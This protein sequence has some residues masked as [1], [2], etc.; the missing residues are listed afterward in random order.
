MV[1]TD[2]LCVGERG[3]VKENPYCGTLCVGSRSTLVWLVMA[4]GLLGPLVHRGRGDDRKDDLC[5]YACWL[6]TQ[7][8][9]DPISFPSL[10]IPCEA[11]GYSC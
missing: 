8:E 6:C 4:D 1:E 3:N 11:P 7:H 10:P 9:C 5:S 2:L